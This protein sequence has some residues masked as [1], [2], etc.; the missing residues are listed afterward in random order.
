MPTDAQQPIAL[1]DKR[2]RGLGRLLASTGVSIA[3]QGMVATA[4]PLLA[5][6]LTR[7]PL[8]VSLVVAATP[9]A[10]LVIGLV[11]GALVDRW[12]RRVVMVVADVVRAVILAGLA[13]AM[14]MGQIT[15]AL[16]I[17]SVLAI[18]LAGC[19]FDPASQASLPVIV[20]RDRHRLATANGWMWGL[21][22][23]GRSMVGPLAGAALFTIWTP[24]PFVVNAATFVVSALLLIGLKQL[25][26]PEHTEAVLWRS[27]RDGVAFLASHRQIRLLT[28]GMTAYNFGYN[29]AFAT[30]VL[31]TQDRLGLGEAE[32]GILL[33][34]AAAGGLLGS[35]L[36]P[37]VQARITPRQT[38]AA[39]LGVQG[40]AWAVLVAFPNAW[41]GGACLAVIGVASMVVTVIGGTARQHLTPDELLGRVS[42]GTRVVGIGAAAIGAVLGGALASAAGLAAP[43]VAA[44]VVLTVTAL[45][46]GLF[47]TDD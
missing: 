24:L 36:A 21:D 23:F 45:M 32:F 37:R 19:F 43:F 31:F 2:P 39:A 41:L 9:T 26:R 47:A 13:T 40:T 16:L 33:A 12:P 18:A 22:M 44:A 14:L 1:A 5:A 25:G 29:L 8:A 10:W 17:V 15:V 20:G 35:W 28:L 7:D 34:V 6:R 30:L 3:G 11:A 46:F 38:Y 42:A 4:A 27:V